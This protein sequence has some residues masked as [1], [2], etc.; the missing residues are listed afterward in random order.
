MIQENTKQWW[1]EKFQSAP[2]RL[3]SKEPSAFLLR[4]A[5]EFVPA[6]KV[7]DLAC[8]EGAQAVALASKGFEVV[9]Y[10][11]SEVALER[12]N[13]LAEES[14]VSITF[15]KLDLDFFMPELMSFDAITIIGMRPSP[16]LTRNLIRGLKKDGWLLIES[17][18]IKAAREKKKE[19][20]ECFKPGEL[21]REFSG[22]PN[23]QVR[24][25]S[26]VSSEWGENNVFLAAQKTEML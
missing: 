18:L 14:G 5:E 10:D 17:S 19:V 15:K 1:D 2:E 7:A 6:A 11:F 20:F 3:Y 23:Y 9:A 26:E 24:F 22:G 12:A 25:Y 16:T 13:K 8:G 4:F 21:L